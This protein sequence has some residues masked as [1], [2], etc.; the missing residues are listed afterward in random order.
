MKNIAS[1]QPE[2]VWR[3][4]AAIT[5]IPRPSKKEEKIAAFLVE[6]A[7]SHGLP[8]KRDAAGNLVITRPASPSKKNAPTVVLQ[9]HMDMVCEKNAG[10]EFDFDREA[11]RAVVDGGWVRAEG[12]TLGADDGIGMAAALAALE[13]EGEELPAIEA[14]FT[15]DEETGLTGAANL[16]PGMLTGKYLI[17]LDSEEEGRL[18]IGCA[19]GV[20]TTATFTYKETA[21]PRDSVFFRVDISGLRGGHSGGDIDKGRGNANRILARLLTRVGARLLPQSGAQVAAQSSA[22]PTRAADG[23][24][25]SRFEGGDKHNAIPREAYCTFAVPVK[26]VAALFEVFDTFAA[27]IRAEFRIADPALE[28]IISEIPPEPT[29][30][31]PAT[32]RALLAALLGVPDGVI[33]MSRAMEGLV[34]TSTNLASIKFIDK[35]RIAVVSLQRSSVESAREYIASAV[36]A[37]FRLAGAEVAHSESYPGWNPDPDSKL[38]AI[39]KSCYEK[40]FKKEPEVRAIHAGLECGLFMRKYPDLE[41]ISFGPTLEGVHSP[42]E[43]MEIASV[44][45][46]WRLLIGVLKAV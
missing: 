6:F 27:D 10:V 43:R 35:H 18:Y 3:N 29:V 2:G 38:L 32:Q 16:G 4:F 37:I 42:G 23:L 15:V 8:C 14:L 31:D 46:F 30:I 36:A 12:T 25:L 20:T 45:R 44:E 19:G 21:A 1:L 26:N 11:I 13:L 41:M 22:R 5:R 9:S 39:V 24:S 33:A 40:L 34:E 17:N 7:R 28:L